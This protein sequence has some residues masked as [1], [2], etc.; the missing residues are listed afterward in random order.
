MKN[1]GDIVS[2]LKQKNY[3]MVNNDLGGGG[4][5]WKNCFITRSFYR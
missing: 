4:V 5:I 2:F 1:N 3:V